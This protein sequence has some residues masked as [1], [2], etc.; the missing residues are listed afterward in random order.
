M[1]LG[2]VQVESPPAPPGAP[3]AIQPL[4][5]PATQEP[6]VL[7]TSTEPSASSPLKIDSSTIRAAG[8]Q[9]KGQLQRLAESSGQQ[10]PGRGINQAEQLAS[11][12][13]GAGKTEC[14][15]SNES[16]SLLSIP[17]IAY[18]ALSGKCK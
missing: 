2:P 8:A 18:A 3:E 7:A 6:P 9:S 13:S 11:R 15:A 17:L 14:L 10:L 4:A 12:V 5:A 1:V 16:G